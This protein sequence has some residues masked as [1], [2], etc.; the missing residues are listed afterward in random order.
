MRRR[1]PIDHVE[2]S[3]LFHSFLSGKSEILEPLLGGFD[4]DGKRWRQAAQRKPEKDDR[5]SRAVLCEEMAAYNRRVGADEA[6][7]ERIRASGAGGTRFVVTGQQPGPLGGPLMT[8]YKIATAMSIAARVESE[9]GVP[10]VPVYWM[11]AD[12]TDFAEIRDFVVASADVTPVAASIASDA[13]AAAAPV[14]A[15]PTRALASIWESVR[16]LIASLPGF[17][18]VNDII[19][20]ALSGSVDH[21]EVTAR[22]LMRLFGGK[23]AVVDGRDASVRRQARSLILEYFDREEEVQRVVEKRGAR[24][25]ERGFHAQLATGPDSGVFLV[26]DGVRRKVTA[27][28][29]REVR[30]HLEGNIQD[31]SPGVILRTLIQDSVFEPI[32]VVLGPAEIAYR[33]QIADLY[34]RL[35][36]PRP[37]AFPRL[38][39]TWVP[40]AVESMVDVVELDAG[41]LATD[42]AGFVAGVHTS[43]SDPR[44]PLAAEGFMERYREARGHFLEEMT[45]VSSEI[46][47]IKVEKRLS[48]VERR[49]RQALDTVSD[50]GKEVAMARWP[51]LSHLVDVFVQHGRVQE[52]Y[53]SAISPWLH[54]PSGA[55]R[56]T[57]N[58]ADEHVDAA[59]DGS[60]EHVVYSC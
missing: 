39:A 8:T 27:E 38:S 12:D 56:A 29:R 35:K 9:Y 52:R 60:V 33:A 26:R 34:G 6:V 25:R 10:T 11:G 53:V 30:S 48:D 36:V 49:L 54:S 28:R 32:A 13:H 59:L 7:V 18:P 42:P 51:F 2:S 20:S 45:V 31:A 3:T 50:G 57:G 1:I 58:V 15:V 4:D 40:P 47:S 17:G 23:I 19:Q 22:V 24:L 55:G 41:L 43:Q 16:P 44:A 46:A 37:I 5:E 21:G 14:G